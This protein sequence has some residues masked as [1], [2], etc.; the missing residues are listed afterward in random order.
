MRATGHGRFG[1]SRT[2]FSRRRTIG[3]GWVA[4]VIANMSETAVMMLGSALAI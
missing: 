1:G 3:D 2:T 4:A